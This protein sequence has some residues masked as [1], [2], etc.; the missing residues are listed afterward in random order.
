MSIRRRLDALEKRAAAPADACPRCRADWV[1]STVL[2]CHPDGTDEPRCIRCGHERPRPAGWIKAY[3]A[4]L[5][6]AGGGGL[7]L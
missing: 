4:S 5:F 3:A 6:A 1:G 7:D 2:C